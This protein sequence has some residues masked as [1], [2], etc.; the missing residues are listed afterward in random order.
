V[1][2]DESISPV[3]TRFVAGERRARRLAASPEAIPEGTVFEPVFVPR[4][5]VSRLAIEAAKRAAGL[6]RPTK[7]T[8]VVWVNADSELAVA[9][10]RIRVETNPASVIVSLP[11]RCDQTGPPA[12]TRRPSGA[13][14]GPS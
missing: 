12:S 2:G 5:V 3:F 13:R 4:D 14:A 8:E 7:R 11:V 6:A 1:A 9:V 10:G